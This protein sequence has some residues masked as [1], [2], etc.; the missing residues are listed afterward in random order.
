VFIQAFERR[1]LTYTPG[2][3]PGF[4]VEFGNIGQHYYL[5]RYGTAITPTAVPAPLPAP[6]PPPLPAPPGPPAADASFTNAL[7]AFTAKQSA[8]LPLGNPTG[9]AYDETFSI[10]RFENGTMYYI[11]STGMIY[12]LSQTGVQLSTYP[13]TWHDGDPNGD[14]AP[15]PR[16][17][18]WIPRR[19]FG[20]VWREN[21]VVQQALGYA[22]ADERAYTGKAQF[23]ERGVLID[24]PDDGTNWALNVFASVWDSNPR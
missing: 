5:W 4:A 12:V 21:A 17:D 3:P 2:N 20:K 14:L 15:G 23:F 19:G 11:K 6:A 1:V 9:T 7:A 13:L 16:A 22:T 8:V 24:D 18:T 10:E